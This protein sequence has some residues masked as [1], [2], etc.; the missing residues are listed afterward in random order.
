MTIE[1]A[2]IYAKLSDEELNK[3]GIKAPKTMRAFADGKKIKYKVWDKLE[4]EYRVFRDNAPDFKGGEEDY[5]IV[6]EEKENFSVSISLLGATI[7]TVDLVKNPAVKKAGNSFPSKEAAQKRADFINWLLFKADENI[8]R[9]LFAFQLSNIEVVPYIPT[10]GT[11]V[12][13][14]KDEL[15]LVKTETNNEEEF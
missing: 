5:I 2:K 3:L 14:S 11:L 6:E 1:Q 13:T 9:A 15:S 12:A 8:I 4:K 10:S 7:T